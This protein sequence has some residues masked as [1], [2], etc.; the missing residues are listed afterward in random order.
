MY[1][2]DNVKTVSNRW[3]G[4][5]PR[6]RLQGLAMTKYGGLLFIGRGRTTLMEHSITHT[7]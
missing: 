5:F 1:I 2:M 3:G 7:S 6:T 4:L